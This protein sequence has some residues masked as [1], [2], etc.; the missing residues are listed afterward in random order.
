MFPAKCQNVGEMKNRYLRSGRLHMTRQ[1]FFVEDHTVWS[2]VLSVIVEHNFLSMCT[3]VWHEH[4]VYIWFARRLSWHCQPFL[5]RSTHHLHIVLHDAVRIHGNT[6][7]SMLM[8]ACKTYTAFIINWYCRIEDVF[9]VK[10]PF[11]SEGFER[12]LRL[13]TVRQDYGFG[14]LIHSN[15]GN[16]EL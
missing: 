7:T 5:E 1:V 2:M 4:C 9:L 12:F 14:T 11:I 15:L 3:W 16:S 13:F 6:G 8:T 10:Y